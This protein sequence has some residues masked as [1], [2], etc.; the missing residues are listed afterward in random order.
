[1]KKILIALSV[2]T[3]FAACNSGS[4]TTGTTKDSTSTMSTTDT[5]KMAPA[6]DTTMKKDSTHMM[7]DTTKK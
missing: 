3:F 1:M 4:S 7:T 2:C 6:M 5:S